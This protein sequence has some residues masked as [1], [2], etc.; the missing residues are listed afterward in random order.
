[1]GQGVTVRDIEDSWGNLDHE[2]FSPA[3]PDLAYVLPRY[4]DTYADHGKAIFGMIFAQHNGYGVDGGAPGAGGRCYSFQI[5]AT[6]QNRPAAMTRMVADSR[7]GNVILLEMQASGPDGNLCPAD[8]DQVIW[9]LTKNATD[10]GVIVVGTA[11]NGGANMDAAAYAAYRARGDNGVIMEGAGSANTSH[12]RLSFSSYGTPVHVQGWGQNVVTTGYGTLANL[13]GDGRQSYSN[14]FSGTSSGGGM[15]AGIVAVLQSYSLQRLGRPL[16]P[17]EM[18]TILITTGIP[19]GGTEHIGPL[20]NLR[21]AVHW[22]DSLRLLEVVPRN[23][24]NEIASSGLFFSNGVIH[25]FVPGYAVNGYVNVTITLFDLKGS[26]ITTVLEDRKS[27]GRYKVDLRRANG[28]LT[29][30]T[31]LCSIKIMGSRYTS[32]VIIR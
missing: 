13:S 6:A 16:A 22:V 32:K 25:Y 18:R 30:G 4:S 8:I 15:M 2:D 19:Q 1:M 28:A 23:I 5:S 20:P 7:R 12:T 31:Y 9:D 3:P 24:K 17:R 14:S 21:A 10:S 29:A 26:L 27:P 11:G